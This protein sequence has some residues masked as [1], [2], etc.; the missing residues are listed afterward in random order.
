M[1]ERSL[2]RPAPG[3][4]LLVTALAAVVCAILGCGQ[5][6]APPPAQ[7]ANTPTAMPWTFTDITAE[8]GIGFEHHNGASDDRLLPETMG[9]GVVVFDA[10]GDTFPDLF[11]VD[12]GPV[13][14]PA[15]T[16]DRASGGLYLNRGDGTFRDATVGSG[17]TSERP[18]LGMGAVAG[19][20][21]NDGDLDLVVTGVGGERL[22]LGRGDGTFADASASW[23]LATSGFA[24]SAA[25]LDADGDGWL[26]LV[27]GRYVVWS[28]EEDLAC[29]PDGVHRTYCTPEA[30]SGVSS[31]L[32]RNL[33]GTGFA[34][35]TAASGV[36]DHAGKTLGI[37]AV[38]LDDDLRPDL[39]VANDT[40]RNF[41]FRN[42]GDG[43][44]EEIGLDAGIALGPSGS[45]RGG[46]GIAAGDL[47]GDGRPDLVIGNFAQEM[48]SVYRQRDGGLFVDDAAVLGVGLPTL[49]EL[50]FGTLTVDLDNDGWLDLVFANGHIEPEIDRFQP[51][52]RY[53]Q[54]LAL[55]HNR[56]G[57]GFDPV[58]APPG[59]SLARP[60]VGR[61]LAAGD[62]DGD[63][64]LDLVVTQNGR[65]AVVLRND[66][67]ARAFLRLRLEGRRSN[68][69]ALGAR[70]EIALTGR[71]LRRWLGAGGSY[72]SATE[73][74]L[75]IGLGE[76][77]AQPEVRVFW[78]SG[79]VQ[80]LGR[81]E[82]GRLH[83]IV[84]AAAAPE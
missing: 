25:L 16:V 84:E 77:P 80:D 55:F 22:Y 35:A 45:P 21:D 33:D 57:E 5:P 18:F 54:P 75:T 62:L 59:S 9:A 67:P 50:A 20:I 69:S 12:S 42:R 14:G 47:D 44:F 82:P 70:V 37:V 11:F 40:T 7:G 36:G 31:R 19:D 13:A 8:V 3:L 30:Y 52:H 83:H 10:D 49:M 4:L 73:P 66:S 74:L 2:L 64:D 26:D 27:V 58:A 61:G 29:R 38:D 1:L 23:G 71:T 51:A 43:T 39:A 34:D 32:Y 79:L 81:L 15:T 68:R 56:E 28:P 6:P 41:L 24:S 17:L 72:L 48:A 78:P 60:L 53:A 76:S 46:M 65:R 63:G